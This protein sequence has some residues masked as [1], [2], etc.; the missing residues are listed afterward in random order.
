MFEGRSKHNRSVF[1]WAGHMENGS[2]FGSLEVLEVLNTNW[3]HYVDYIG[4]DPGSGHKMKWFKPQQVLQCT[5]FDQKHFQ[6]GDLR[7]DIFF[8]FPQ[9]PN[10]SITIFVSDRLRKVSRTLKSNYE[11]YSGSRI[12]LEDLDKAMLKKFYFT[13]EQTELSPEVDK[14]VDI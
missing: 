4:P 14:W 8:E 5:Y 6:N 11:T 12:V 3:S 2:T 10:V 13:F 9:R 7:T 1:G